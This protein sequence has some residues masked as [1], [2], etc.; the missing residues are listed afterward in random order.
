MVKSRPRPVPQIERLPIPEPTLTEPFRALVIAD[1]HLGA[2]GDFG[3][4]RLADQ[5]RVLR[6]A[7]DIATDERC[8]V[9]L[10]AGDAFHRRKPT[11]AE[12]M[13]L[14]EFLARLD[15]AGIVVLSI[16]GNHDVTTMEQPDALTVHNALGGLLHYRRPGIER[17]GDVDV[18]MLPWCPPG[19]A[20]ADWI[21]ED[22]WGIDAAFRSVADGLV[23]VA[24]GLRA[25]CRQTRA[26]ILMLH[27]SVG[28]AVTPTGARTDTFRET[29][30]PL[31]ALA[32]MG[33]DAVV[34]GHIHLAQRLDEQV[35]AR[36]P[37]FYPGSPAV[38]DWGEVGEWHGVSVLTVDGAGVR[39]RQ[40]TLDDRVFYPV[41]VD[42]TEADE[43]SLALYVRVSESPPG[44]VVRVR[45]T[46]T[47]EQYRRI[48]QREIADLIED[49]GA[50]LYAVQPT[51]R[52]LVRA[53]VEGLDADSIGPLEALGVYC[54]AQ[55]IEAEDAALMA[56][57][58]SELLVEIGAG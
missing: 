40:H 28:G 35:M 1:V 36:G 39:I 38:V 34:C 20:L 55:E 5:R 14:R 52:R 6:T 27:W 26:A 51:I 47:E 7:A 33:W 18:A 43:P 58:A 11:P 56:R 41:D 45:Y 8:D 17:L 44:S 24:W 13:V 4:D 15:D 57:R 25:A 21:G 22:A 9:V 16:A 32:E 29:V 10:F 53:S 31:D 30:I 48:E 19:R 37:I 49:R 54:K 42:V 50:Y 3:P 46:A 12:N 23:D 2:G